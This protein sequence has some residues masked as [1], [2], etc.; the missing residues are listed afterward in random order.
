M[1]GFFLN[2]CQPKKEEGQSEKPRP[3]KPYIIKDKASGQILKYAAV[4][5]S[6]K[7]SSLS[8]PVSGTVKE[9]NVDL[10]QQVSKGNVL[11]KLD[12]DTFIQ[13][14][15]GAKAEVGRINSDLKAI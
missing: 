9:V 14:V 10:G 3:I 4:T 7:F 12:P 13:N 11:V 1:S 15:Y 6:S 2:A 8:F 5:E